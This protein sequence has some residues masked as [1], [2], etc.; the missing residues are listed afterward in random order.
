[1][2][3]TLAGGRSREGRPSGMV[4]ELWRQAKVERDETEAA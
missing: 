4:L 1:M 2:V 3:F